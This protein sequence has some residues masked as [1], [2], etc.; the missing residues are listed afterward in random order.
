MTTTL[1]SISRVI[2][3]EYTETWD[4]LRAKV[5]DNITKSTPVWALLRMLGCFKP[6]VGGKYIDRTVRYNLPVA[7][8]VDARGDTLPNGERGETKTIAQ[9]RWRTI[10]QGVQRTLADDQENAGEFQVKSY[11]AESL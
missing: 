3:T 5:M 6:Q 11:V 10:S 4:K 2:D 9:W 7:Q 1:P 8:A